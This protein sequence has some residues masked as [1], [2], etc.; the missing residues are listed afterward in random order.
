MINLI[1]PKCN[2]EYSPKVLAVHARLCVIE[3]E[4]IT[5]N[6]PYENMDI[7]EIRELA[8]ERGVSNWW[9]RSRETLEIKL[10]EGDANA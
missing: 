2:K 5:M 8:K 10:S 3:E 9:N 1:C 4:T 6:C 7:E